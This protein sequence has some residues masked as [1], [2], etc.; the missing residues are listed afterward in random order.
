MTEAKTHII[1]FFEQNLRFDGRKLDELRK[2]EIQTGVTKNAEGSARVKIGETEVIAGVKM[3]V[4]TPYPDT[5]DDGNMIINV[6]LLPLSSPEFEAGPPNVVSIEIARITDRSIRE[7]KAIDT[8]KL[9]IEPAKKVWAVSIDIATINNDGNLIDA[10]A[11]AAIAAIRDTRFPSYEDGV[12]NYK[13]LTEERIPIKKLPVTVTINKI[14]K[15]Y[16]VD[17]SYDEEPLIEAR[18]T[19]GVTKEG[20]VCALQKGGSGLLSED[21]VSEMLRLAIDKSRELGRE[22]N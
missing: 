2:V 9:C 7:S 1:R 12:V 3:S 8:K 19:A 11:L 21:E 13:K 17:S 18:L 10:S 16:F 22:I 15:Y 20:N 4:E 14:G 6:E 5:P